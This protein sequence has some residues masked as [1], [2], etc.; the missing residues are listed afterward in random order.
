MKHIF[1]FIFTLLLLHAFAQASETFLKKDS[2]IQLIKK[3]KNLNKQIELLNLLNP[4]LVDTPDLLIKNANFT[5]S[6]YA[7]LKNDFGYFESL[8]FLGVGHCEKRNF[9]TSIICLQNALNY[10]IKV[11]NIPL[12]IR[13]NNYLGIAFEGKNNYSKALA[14]YF[15]ALKNAKQIN[16][17]VYLLKSLNNIGVVYL[18]KNDYKLA[19]KHLLQAEKIALLIDSELGLINYNLALV[20]LERKEY[21]KA[22]LKFESVLIDDFKSKNQKNI[23]ETFNNIGLCYLKLNEIKNA[24]LYFNKAFEIREK[25]NDENGQRNS[26]TD[27]AELHIKNK[28]FDK[29]ISLLNRAMILAKRTN[30]KNGQIY[31]YEAFILCFKTQNNYKLALQYTELKEALILEISNEENLEKL[32]ELEKQAQ[33]KQ[34]EAENEVYFVKEKSKYLLNGVVLLSIILVLSIIVFLFYTLKNSQKNNRILKNNQT[35]L[36][37]KNNELLI[38]NEKILKNQEIAKEALKTKAVFIRNISHEI[39]TPLNAINGISE[40]LKTNSLTSEQ[41]NLLAILQSS[42]L[43]LLELVNNILDF[44]ALESGESE[45]NYISFSFS[46]VIK[47]LDDIFKSKVQ[48]KGI[49]FKIES[50]IDEAKKFKSDPMRIAQVLSNFINNSLANTKE[51]TIELL[52]EETYTSYFKSTILFKVTDTGIGIPENKKQEIFEVFSLVDDSNTRKKDGA[53]LGLAICQKIIQGLGGL[54]KVESEIGKGCSFFFE[55]S[56]DITDSDYINNYESIENKTNLIRGLKILL[57]EDSEINVIILS[58]FLNKWGCQ[59]DVAENGIIGLNKAKL[60]QYDLILMDIQMPEM[61][62]IACTKA[63]RNLNDD[64]FKNIPIIALTAAF[65]NTI[66]EAAFLAGMNDYIMKP[67]S[68]EVLIEKLIRAAQIKTA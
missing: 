64:Y 31:V 7:E 28:Q 46:Q 50:N 38:Q 48:N 61:D 2:I 60:K 19:E 16:D 42:N 12:T 21:Q 45:F 37:N 49:A 26:L 11:K 13:C 10:F 6:K 47:G 23:A 18:L 55:L 3:E 53:G 62:G 14:Y 54:I 36:T 57:V 43:K 29:A 27:I 63:I 17:S 66:K 51:G 41:S 58:Q 34:K 59:F 15:Q 67:F 65:E 4:F 22:L 39:R 5:L 52:I 8:H 30:N 44:S 33:V 40:L 25:I 32:T 68:A 56:L 24:E 20:Y 9:D 35:Q 1:T